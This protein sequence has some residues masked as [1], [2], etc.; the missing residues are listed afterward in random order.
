VFHRSS[1]RRAA[2]HF[3][4]LALLSLAAGLLAG[5]ASERFSVAF[6]LVGFGVFLFY[7]RR[8]AAL[9]IGTG[10][11]PRVFPQPRTARVSVTHGLDSPAAPTLPAPIAHPK[12]PRVRRRVPGRRDGF[13]DSRR[14]R[15]QTFR[16]IP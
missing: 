16:R 7:A 1:R 11:T 8:T 5:A 12:L 4:V 2:I 9:W 14:V 15:P 10:L 3:A 13:S 6:V